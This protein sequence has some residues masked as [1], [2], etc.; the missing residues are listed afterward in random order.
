[1][2]KIKYKFAIK[3]NHFLPVIIPLLIMLYPVDGIC[4]QEVKIV[5]KT[6]YA[7]K[8][9]KSVDPRIKNLVKD[10]NSAFVY[11][12]YELLDQKNL[13]LNKGEN[14]VFSIHGGKKVSITSRG[15]NGGKASLEIKCNK[16]N[17]ELIKTNINFRDNG[18]TTIALPE[19]KGDKLFL[20]ILTSF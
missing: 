15:V 8:N 9:K 14:T 13:T 5:V 7:S 3:W 6:I 17:K 18:D 2:D 4:D 1:M 11:S 10:L 20:H 16:G 19:G 12:S